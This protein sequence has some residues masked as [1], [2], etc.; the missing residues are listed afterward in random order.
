MSDNSDKWDEAAGK[1]QAAMRQSYLKKHGIEPTGWH[2]LDWLYHEDFA[3]ETHRHI[4][5][6]YARSS[7]FTV[8]RPRD[9][10]RSFT[11]QHLFHYNDYIKVLFTGVELRALDDEPVFM[12]LVHY[13]QSVALGQPFKFTL[14]G[15]I[16]DLGWPRNGES[17]IRLKDCFSRLSA[18]E[19]YF[20]NTKAYGKSPVFRL[21]KHYEATN[22][23]NGNVHS[24]QAV[25]DRSLIIFFAGNTF[26]SHHWQTYRKLS[27]VARR[28]ADYAGSHKAPYDLNIEMF[29]KL[30][31][32][33]TK[34]KRSWRQTVRQACAELEGSGLVV[35][36]KLPHGK[37]GI[38]FIR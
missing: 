16:E 10:R 23:A 36:A 15:F 26:T 11:R 14:S 4:P 13:G 5:N 32:S 30:C 6:E 1:A 17:Y 3:L 28:L 27:P 21:L 8:R 7:L 9:A 2:Q 25:L 33:G 35:S 34:N 18:A 31:D 29:R 37:E 24:Y 19:L 22:D 20:E 38:G 12:Q